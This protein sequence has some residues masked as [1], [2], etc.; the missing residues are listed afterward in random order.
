MFAEHLDLSEIPDKLLLL[1]LLSWRIN[2]IPLNVYGTVS[3]KRES[4]VK[5]LQAFWK[6]DAREIPE[7]RAKLRAPVKLATPGDF[8]DIPTK[9]SNYYKV[10]SIQQLVEGCYQ[11]ITDFSW[12]WWYSIEAYGMLETFIPISTKR[13][14]YRVNLLA[15]LAKR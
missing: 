15:K 13:A 4:S 5:T 7:N 1:L 2:Q 6:L 11:N 14:N 8:I 12:V 9:F 10:C 3:T